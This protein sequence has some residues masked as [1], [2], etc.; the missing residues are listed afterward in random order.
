MN[1]HFELGLGHSNSVQEPQLIPFTQGKN[2]TSWCCAW[3]NTALVVGKQILLF[4]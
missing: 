4:Q 1:E 2:I 3:F